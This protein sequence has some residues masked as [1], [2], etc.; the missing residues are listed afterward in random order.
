[1]PLRKGKSNKVISTNIKRLMHEGKK[2]SQA[3]AIS[4]RKAGKSRK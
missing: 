2:Q 1:M 4:M 3:I